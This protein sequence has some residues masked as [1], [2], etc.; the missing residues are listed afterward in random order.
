MGM[1]RVDHKWIDANQ[2]IH[3][4]IPRATCADQKGIDGNGAV[5]RYLNIKKCGYCT[6]H[7]VGGI[8]R[9]VP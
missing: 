2:D 4:V 6:I 5:P 1:C 8:Q 7:T 3:V 9:V